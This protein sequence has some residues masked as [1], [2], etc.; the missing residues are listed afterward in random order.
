MKDLPRVA[1][2]QE[3]KR[4]DA[5]CKMVHRVRAYPALDRQTEF[6]SCRLVQVTIAALNI[7]LAS[8]FPAAVQLL[9]DAN[10]NLF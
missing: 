7:I 1:G 2:K 9:A 3:Y 4:P 5:T 6:D 8:Q 10:T